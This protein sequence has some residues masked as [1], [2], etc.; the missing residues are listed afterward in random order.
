MSQRGSNAASQ[1]GRM[2]D[3]EGEGN[4]V[5]QQ[6]ARSLAARMDALEHTYRELAHTTRELAQTNRSILALLENRQANTHPPTY[7]H[8]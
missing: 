2:E 5:D 6:G 8:H 1:V 3:F 4:G 7:K